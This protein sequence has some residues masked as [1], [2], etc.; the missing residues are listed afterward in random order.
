MLKSF[1]KSWFG[2]FTKDELKKFIGLAL[3]FA[4]TIGVYWFLRTSKD[5]VFNAIVGF[6]SQPYA[7]WLSVF[8]IIPLTVAYGWLVDRLPR[9]RVFYA[10][11]AIYGVGAL[12]FALALNN[13]S[14]GLLNPVASPWRLL[15]WAYY[16]FVES[17]GSI[18]VVLFWS[19]AADVTTPEA[20]KRGYPILAIGAQ[21]G[22]YI[23]SAVNSGR[24]GK[25]TNFI[26]LIASC[27]ICIILIGLMVR[28]FLAVVPKEELRSYNTEVK[29]ESKPKVGMLDGFKF[30]LSQPYLL[31]IYASITIYEI[32]VTL[33]D[34]RFKSMVGEDVARIVA[35][36]PNLPKEVIGK[37]KTALF[38]EWSGL[39]GEWTAILALASLLLGIGS[40]GRKLGLTASL[41]LLPLL[42]MPCAIYLGL[43]SSLKV[44]FAVMVISKG[45]NYALYQPSKEQ[46]YIPTS[47]EAKYKSKAFIEMFGSRSSKAMGSGLNIV[48]KSPMLA[49][50]FGIISMG[51]SLSLALAWL[52]ISV[53]LGRRHKD[54]VSRNEVVC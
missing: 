33:F 19:F 45:I 2:D 49:S 46:L 48:A 6:D 43:A 42:L 15:G 17:F 20:A 9:Q 36:D 28:L 5:G 13:S 18:M 44:A 7:K 4:F 31:G 41:V 50:S 40:I 8:F 47:K 23:G 35:E 14:I 21:I 38:N 22:A 52:L 10:L 12:F 24:F 1:L 3:I 51:F 53:Y 16:L 27:A 11:A 39:M 32:I 25:F 30:L 26:P 54:A 34:F 29:K 37:L